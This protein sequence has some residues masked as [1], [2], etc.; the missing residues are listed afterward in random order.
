MNTHKLKLVNTTHRNLF[1]KLQPP[2]DAT[3]PTCVS[4]NL[5][6]RDSIEV[7]VSDFYGVMNLFVCDLES[8]VWEGIIPVKTSI[9]IYIHNILPDPED[10]KEETSKELY[11]THGGS[12]IPRGFSAQDPT[13][14]DTPKESDTAPNFSNFSNLCKKWWIVILLIFLL[15]FAG[16]YCIYF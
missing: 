10:T 5:M 11:V 8:Q 1:I 13:K 7:N 14:K 9:P 15:L 3:Y 2:E 12:T 4:P 6:A 16:L